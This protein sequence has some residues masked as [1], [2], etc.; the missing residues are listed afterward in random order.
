M[1]RRSWSVARGASATGR[2]AAALAGVIQRDI[3]TLF[4][5]SFHLPKGRSLGQVCGVCQLGMKR[6]G[7]LVKP[8]SEGLRD[9]S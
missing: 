6:T 9:H 4:M 3:S 1:N 7:S 5:A 8:R 2:R